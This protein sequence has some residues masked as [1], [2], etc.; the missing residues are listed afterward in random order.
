MWSGVDG[1]CLPTIFRGVNGLGARIGGRMLVDVESC[2][3]MMTRNPPIKD[4]PN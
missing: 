3:A 4:V 1:N 2:C